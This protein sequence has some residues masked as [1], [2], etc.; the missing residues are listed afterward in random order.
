MRLNAYI[1]PQCGG[2]LNAYENTEI[3]Q[4]P[5]CKASIRISYEGEKV[6]G[7]VTISDFS[8]EF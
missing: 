7:S 8:F 2:A 5:H 3:T 6:T 1:C 4:C